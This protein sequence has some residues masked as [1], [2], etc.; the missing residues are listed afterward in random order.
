MKKLCAVLGFFSGLIVLAGSGVGLTYK[1]DSNFKDKFD[2]TFKLNKY[3][4]EKKS[5]IDN[6][7]AISDHEKNEK[8]IEEL[9]KQIE[10]LTK[11]NALLNEKLYNSESSLIEQMRKYDSVVAERDEFKADSEL[12]ESELKKAEDLINSLEGSDDEKASVIS[13]LN[14]DL[15]GA[16]NEISILKTSIN[17]NIALINSLK[18]QIEI[19][20]T[21]ND[22]L[23]LSNQSNSETISRLTSQ[24]KIL[25]TRISELSN[26]VIVYS[27]QI[28]NLNKQ[29][30]NLTDSV[31]FYEA[32]LSVLETNNE[33]VVI[34]EYDNVPISIQVVKKGSKVSVE[35]PAN[36]TGLTFNYWMINNEEIDLDNYIV[37]AN[38]KI[39]ANIIYDYE[40]KYIGLDNSE[41]I[42]RVTA[43]NFGTKSSLYEVD[44]IYE[45]SEGY[46]VKFLGWSKNNVDIIDIS[47][48]QITSNTVFFALF[49]KQI[50]VEF[51]ID[52]YKMT[53]TDF[54]F[55]DVIHTLNKTSLQIE[56]EIKDTFFSI[57]PIKS[58]DGFSLDDG[59]LIDL[60][61][62][63]FTQST[64]KVY[65]NATY[66]SKVEI[67]DINGVLLET[68]YADN[69]DRFSV[70]S[71]SSKTLTTVSTVIDM[72]NGSHKVFVG[73]KN[74]KDFVVN[75]DGYYYLTSDCIFL[76]NYNE[77]Y[78]VNFLNFEDCVDANMQKYINKTS[79]LIV[80]KNIG[81][82]IMN[83][84]T[85]KNGY[86][87]NGFIINDDSNK[88]YSI[89][90]IKA[91]IPTSDINISYNYSKTLLMAS[92][93]II[94][95][96]AGEFSFSLPLTTSNNLKIGS[97][98]KI[99]IKSTVK[100]NYYT[101][102]GF[103]AVS[104]IYPNRD[105]SITF[106][107]NNLD[108]TLTFGDSY[109]TCSVK[110]NSSN[111]SLVF[112]FVLK[113]ITIN[114]KIYTHGLSISPVDIAVQ[115]YI[116]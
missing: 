60:Q 78:Y 14:Q 16:R 104:K 29:I 25:N 41:T 72:E 108:E 44:S 109:F 100:G 114:S 63:K 19:L 38:V 49:E 70:S 35:V 56:E 54:F 91:L 112:N 26:Q 87:L 95:S 111:N 18:D 74:N 88:V 8:I 31:T 48:S 50:T 39:K 43:G 67:K 23:L 80:G 9:N 82:L 76:P 102:S 96:K 69:N 34:F 58:V 77:V 107:E 101:K 2:R 85:V 7:S 79:N 98:N 94:I 51:Y 37:T 4:V 46:K 62:Y 6:A 5:D 27:N 55:G 75:S 113:S 1:L 83:I 17:N 36:K 45:N 97:I 12:K 71:I 3:H 92:K 21:L 89:D 20:K 73:W 22:S 53:Y 33:A 68:R 15:V 93:N 59:T 115:G 116:D 24:I 10:D 86:A 66:K 11:N 105:F 84:P 52:D 90:E 47:N 40:V 81:S 13:A 99:L 103:A 110:Y 32:Y 42:E 28:V 61:T 57:R 65:V 64:T 106:N 30:S